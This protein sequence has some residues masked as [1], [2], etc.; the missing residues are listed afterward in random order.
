M[1]YLLVT[2]V[3]RSIYA[4]D[5]NLGSYPSGLAD[6]IVSTF[7]RTCLAALTE[8]AFCIRSRYLK[9]IVIWTRSHSYLPTGESGHCSHAIFEL[10][11]ISCLLRL[12]SFATI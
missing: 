11:Q 5:D 8:G 9:V 1:S 3:T 4:D 6:S 12:N 2:I 7:S 10:L